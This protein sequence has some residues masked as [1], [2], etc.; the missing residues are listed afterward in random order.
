M[1][2]TTAGEKK[3]GL[4]VKIA[5]FVLILAQMTQAL[6][7]PSLTGIMQEFPDAAT[8]T[9]QTILNIPTLIMIVSSAFTG[10]LAKRFGYKTMGII[11]F[12]FCIV[13]GVLPGFIHPSVGVMI[14][15]RGVFGIGY[16]MVYALC[17]AAC[18][19]FWTGRDTSSM[20]G[21]VAAFAGLAGVVYSL[22][23]SWL[24]TFGWQC[25]YYMYFINVAFMI[26]YAIFMPQ[27]NENRD[28]LYEAAAE[29]KEGFS[30]K[31]FGAKYWIFLV[32]STI[33]IGCLTPFMNNMTMICAQIGLSASAA[34]LILMMFCTG[35]LLGGLIYIVLYRVLK[36]LCMP[37]MLIVDGIV[38]TLIITH[39]SFMLMMV[40]GV[41][42]GIVWQCLN[43]GW[44]DMSNKKVDDYPAASANAVSLFIAAQGI[45]Q[46]IA[47][48]WNS[49]AANLLGQ[50]Q[51]NAFYQ[52]YPVVIILFASGVVLAIL[53]IIHKNHV[54]YERE[55]EPATEQ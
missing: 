44:Q 4:T 40:A 37:I 6:C 50:T 43:C 35:M 8:T 32:A 36:R 33:G 5:V 27:R 53:A 12:V 30:V 1:A 54:D 45:G 10:P 34:P 25:L 22:L 39:A 29:K 17:I 26:Y 49:G 15:E 38:F 47:P 2:Q 7:N 28:A 46:F 24:V 20:L 11:A 21:F 3:Y 55:E 52:L 19:E 48:Y 9:L 23:S 18:G 41:A 42:V 51:E 31:G 16:G 14:A 13:G